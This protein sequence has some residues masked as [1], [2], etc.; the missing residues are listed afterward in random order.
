MQ[1]WLIPT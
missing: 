1:H